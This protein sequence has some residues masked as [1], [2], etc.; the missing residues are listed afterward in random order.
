MKK[1][2]TIQCDSG[3]LEVHHASF[4]LLGSVSAVVAT[5]NF[6]DIR[7]APGIAN[8]IGASLGTLG[9]ALSMAKVYKLEKI[10]DR[11]K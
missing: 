8:Y 5:A 9:T 2:S 11:S 6:I 4:L 7:Y 3:T 10:M 1:T